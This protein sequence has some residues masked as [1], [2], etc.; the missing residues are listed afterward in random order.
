VGLFGLLGFLV[1]SRTREIGIRVALGAERRDVGWM[2]IRESLMLVGTGLLIGLPLSYAAARVLSGLLYGV[3][4]M[5][6]TPLMLAVA[7]L[8]GVVGIAT[9]IPVRRATAVD[10]MVAL[11]YE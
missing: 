5:P 1:I 11:R 7:I 4:A 8:L 3:G 9:L 2:V 10:P 6:I